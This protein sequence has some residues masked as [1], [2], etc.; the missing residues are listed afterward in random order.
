MRLKACFGQNVPLHWLCW[1]MRRI[2][3]EGRRLPL[4]SLLV[5]PLIVWTFQA[6]AETFRVATYN[7]NN[8]LDAP[9]ETR[10]A[11]SDE[12][13][14]KIRES[15]LAIKPDVLAMEE[16]GTLSALEELRGSL[17][18]EGLNFPNWEYV[19]G[20]D[21]NIHIAVLSKFPF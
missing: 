12:S 14:A 3:P 9:T 7:L 17:K 20:F 13:K 21:T 11:K 16:I 2:R 8:Y 4:R 19:C 5:I 15:I 6:D 10:R 1:Q 18:A